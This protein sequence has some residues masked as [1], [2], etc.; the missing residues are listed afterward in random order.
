MEYTKE[1]LKN[2]EDKIMADRFSADV[3]IEH[4]ETKLKELQ[5]DIKAVLKRI[6][7]TATYLEELEAKKKD[8][9]KDKELREQNKNLIAV[10]QDDLIK[11]SQKKT[12]L[13]GREAQI[14]KNIELYK[15][16]LETADESLEIA[17]SKV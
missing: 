4:N 13:E 10:M 7:K 12:D 8:G 3:A 9:I 5:S 11:R 16:F 17:K 6:K 14:K 1:I 15:D 2:Y